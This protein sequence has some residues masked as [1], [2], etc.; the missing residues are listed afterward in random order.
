MYG[1]KQYSPPQN[2]CIST[3]KN[4]KTAGVGHAGSPSGG[5]HAAN[6]RHNGGGVDQV[7]ELSLPVL[8]QHALLTRPHHE[9]T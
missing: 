2:I 4:M 3:V 5:G 9:N 7:A 1:L 8:Q 6:S